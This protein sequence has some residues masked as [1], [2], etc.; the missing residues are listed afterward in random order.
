[1]TARPSPAVRLVT[2]P[3]GRIYVN[4]S[5]TGS[6][7]RQLLATG[8]YEKGW[9]K[10]MKRNITTGQRALDV[11]ANVGYYTALLCTL[12]GST[13]L[14]MACEPDP[15]N[16]ALLR[17]TMAANGFA[18]AR[19]IE[20]AVADQVARTVLFQDE[21]WH[22]VHSLAA[23]NRVNPGGRSADV[24]TVTLD[25][26][27]AEAGPFDF[28]KID[29]QGAEGRILRAA[30]SLLNQPRATVLI[31]MWPSGLAAFGDTLADVTGP[32]LQ[33]GF[34]SYELNAAW[35]LVPVSADDIERQAAAM[36]TWSSF[37]LVWRK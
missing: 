9:T 8:K 30:S 23:A 35:D 14:V 32:F 10:W 26:L 6:V 37:N 1:M 36:T 15:D 27:A 28:V 18:H 34:G 25:H 16:A 7:A 20:A 2:T 17:R 21:A 33:H 19:V 31:E 5:D 13:G 29:A 12:V 3:G 11:G 22:G 24:A 4:E